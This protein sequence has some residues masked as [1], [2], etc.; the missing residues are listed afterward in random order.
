[1]SKARWTGADIPDLTGKTILVTGSTSG[2]GFESVKAFS[3]K[4]ANVIMAS[5]TIEKGKVAK[6]LILDQNSKCKID[7][8]ELE[9]TDS[10][11]IKKFATTFKES[12]E[13]LDILINNAGIMTVPYDVKKDGFESQ[14][15][16]NHL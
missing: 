14:M 4:G 3:N 8:M 6:A 2:L 15:G 5:R 13:Q 12:H 10:D 1:M 11:S 9:L 7:V 16:T